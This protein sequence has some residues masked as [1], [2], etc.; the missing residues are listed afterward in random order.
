[1]SRQQVIVNIQDGI[2]T[3]HGTPMSVAEMN[4]WLDLAKKNLLDQGRPDGRMGAAI[5]IPTP[6]Q[7]RVLN[8]N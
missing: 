6:E 2:L 4:L 7:A 5:E 8:G 1:M 3:V